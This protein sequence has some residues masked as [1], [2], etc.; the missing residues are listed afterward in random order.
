MWNLKKRYKWTY[1]QIRNRPTDIE[2]ILL[3]NRKGGV[4]KLGIWD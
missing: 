1:M 2:K 3:S 4:D